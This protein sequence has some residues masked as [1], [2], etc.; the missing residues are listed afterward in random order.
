ML[1]RLKPDPT[2]SVGSAFRR[3]IV[4]VLIMLVSSAWA[5][6]ATG[7]QYR[8]QRGAF[9]ARS[10]WILRLPPYGNP[11]VPDAEARLTARL[12]DEALHRGRTNPY[13]LWPPYARLWGEN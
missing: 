7:L 3:T 4:F 13:L 10:E 1:V 11:P 8:L 5:W 2:N 6:R 9:E 12:R